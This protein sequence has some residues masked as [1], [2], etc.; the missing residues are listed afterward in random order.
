MTRPWETLTVQESPGRWSRDVDAFVAYRQEHPML[1]FQ[2]ARH[3]FPRIPEWAM[4]MFFEKK[5]KK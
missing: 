2:A 4:R 1:T 3:K 5:E